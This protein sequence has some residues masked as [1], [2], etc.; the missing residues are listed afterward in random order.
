MPQQETPK[1]K[2]DIGAEIE[3]LI[4]GSLALEFDPAKRYVIVI[5][6]RKWKMVMSRDTAAHIYNALARGGIKAAVLLA[7]HDS[8]KMFSLEVTDES[9][10]RSNT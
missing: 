8:V 3:A 1:A 5:D 10:E 9:D 4:P 6:P 7:P 2:I